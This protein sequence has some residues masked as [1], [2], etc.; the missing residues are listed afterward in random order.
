MSHRP[1]PCVEH[2]Y[3]AWTTEA[4]TLSDDVI[5]F[6]FRRYCYQCGAVDEEAATTTAQWGD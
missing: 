4:E 1:A 3:S 2:V 6:V 5:R